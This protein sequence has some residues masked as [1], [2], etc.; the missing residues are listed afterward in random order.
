MLFAAGMGVGLM[1]WGVAEP[2]M[3]FT[4]APGPPHGTPAAARHAMVLADFHW[5]LHAWAVYCIA[6]LILAYFGFRRGTPYL[7]GAP[8]RSAFSG[9]WVAPVAWLA[10]FAAV[11]SVAL[12]VAGSVGLGVFQLHSGL[13][14]LQG[15]DRDSPVVA[16][17]IL[18][19]LF[20]VYMPAVVVN[21]DTG[22]KWLSNACISVSILVM[23]YISLVGPT[24][25]VLNSFLTAVGDYVSG[26]VGLSFQ[27][28]PYQDVG[29]WLGS[30]TLTY[31]IWYIAWAPFVGVFIAR[32][33]L[34]RTIREFVVG[35]LLVPSLFSILWFA[36]FGG[37]A[38]HEELFGTG[39]LVELVRQDVSV[40]LFSLFDRF[41]LAGLLNRTALVLAFGFLVTSVVSA[42]FVLG[43]F[44]SGGAL[45]PSVGQKVAWGIILGGLGTAMTLAGDVQALRA[46]A[47]IGAV[48]FTLILLL[49]VAALLRALLSDFG[50]EAGQ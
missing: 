44:T 9:R 25:F 39:G 10:D 5:A 50:P 26:I 6:G 35:V 23:L 19:A 13:H 48:P 45:N 17:C 3:H 7:P 37:T 1:F 24:Q 16:V 36:V 31:L 33:S 46:I 8:L 47:V 2:L 38:L 30:W 20:I 28:Y 41:P 42:A 29:K 34:G 15:Y 27:V 49:Q 11:T 32:I 14:V 43:M 21:L 22:M 18:A 12:G 4:E 40:A